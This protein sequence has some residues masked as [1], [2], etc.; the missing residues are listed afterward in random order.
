MQ[1]QGKTVVVTGGGRGIGREIAKGFAA[2]G[3]H[4]ALF[5]LPTA[6]QRVHMRANIVADV[7]GLGV[8]LHCGTNTFR[9]PNKYV[10][11]RYKAAADA[12]LKQVRR[13][14]KF[15]RSQGAE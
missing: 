2:R 3:A 8:Q 14:A 13:A 9:H 6:E 12:R 15:R 7:D 1:L 10:H 5:D 4:V 11:P